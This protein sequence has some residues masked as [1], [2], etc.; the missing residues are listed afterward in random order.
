MDNDRLKDLL[1]TIDRTGEIPSDMTPDEQKYCAVE[2]LVETPDGRM[3]EA[4]D[5]PP[6]SEV[7]PNSLPEVILIPRLTRKGK[8]KLA[9]LNNEV[10]S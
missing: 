1:D 2:G 10:T 5:L 8:E 4:Y 9:Q 7:D 6:D 3:T